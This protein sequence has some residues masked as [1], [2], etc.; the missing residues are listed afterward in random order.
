MIQI[1]SC[2]KDIVPL[3]GWI[4]QVDLAKLVDETYFKFTQLLAISQ[5]TFPDECP[6]DPEKLH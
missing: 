5:A 2:A 1:E 4:E 6:Y 3:L